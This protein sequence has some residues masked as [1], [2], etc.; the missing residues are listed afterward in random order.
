MLAGLERGV[1]T[2]NGYSGNTPP[3][4][5]L[6]EPQLTTRA[7]LEQWLARFPNSPGG[8]QLCVVEL[9]LDPRGQ[10]SAQARK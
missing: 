7:Q 1:P 6:S 2:L 4:W 5:D 8:A 3:G 10:I 9:V